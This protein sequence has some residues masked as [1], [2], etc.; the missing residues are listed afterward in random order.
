MIGAVAGRI[1]ATAI[2]QSLAASG[3]G[4]AQHAQCGK[5]TDMK[6]LLL[7]TLLL[8]GALGSAAWAKD[9]SFCNENLDPPVGN[10]HVNHGHPNGH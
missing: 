6:K 9:H 7:I 10:C 1:T 4:C 8:L 3:H 2:K 5:E